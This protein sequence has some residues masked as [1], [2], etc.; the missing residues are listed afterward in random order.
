MRQASVEEGG[1][2]E[3]DEET[4]K[5]G[6]ALPKSAD[7]LLTVGNHLIQPPGKKKSRLLLHHCEDEVH[8]GGL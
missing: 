8:F 2:G 4:N 7:R 3:D 1:G 6:P 5:M